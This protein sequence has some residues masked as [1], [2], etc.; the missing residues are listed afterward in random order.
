M[1]EPREAQSTRH[2]KKAQGGL[3]FTTGECRPQFKP[4]RKDE[5]GQG[6]KPGAGEGGARASRREQGKRVSN[7]EAGAPS[8]RRT[9]GVGVGLYIQK[10]ELIYDGY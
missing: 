6:L 2:S 10:N 7:E 8:L 5:A 3:M 9:P 4:G 1:R